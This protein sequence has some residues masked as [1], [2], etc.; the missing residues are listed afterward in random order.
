MEV[1]VQIYVPAALIPGKESSVP[2]GHEAASDGC[3]PKS[4]WTLKRRDNF[5]PFRESNPDSLIV[6]PIAQSLY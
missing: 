1:R 3:V 5:S 6:Q 4:T 2:F